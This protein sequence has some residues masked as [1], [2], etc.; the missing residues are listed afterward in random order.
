MTDLIPAK[1]PSCG[2]NLEFLS[3]LKVGHC[4]HCGGKVIISSTVNVQVQGQAVIPCPYCSGKGRTECKGQQKVIMTVKPWGWD[5]VAESCGGSGKC[6]YHNRPA[7][8]PTSVSLC[9]DGK[10]DNCKGKGRSVLHKCEFCNGAGACPACQGSGKCTFCG[11]V[12][13]LPCPACKGTGF[14]VYQGPAD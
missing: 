14:K 5:N 11:G 8:D 3:G 4:M 10:C 6:T 2:A 12:G 9:K 13:Y 1:C 7:K